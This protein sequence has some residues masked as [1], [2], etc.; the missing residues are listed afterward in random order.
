MK[1]AWIKFDAYLTA[2]LV[3]QTYK[4]EDADANDEP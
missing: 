4:L 3:S 2:K 1:N